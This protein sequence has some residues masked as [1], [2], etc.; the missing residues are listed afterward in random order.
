MIRH[1]TWNESGWDTNGTETKIE[2]QISNCQ[3]LNSIRQP[4]KNCTRSRTLIGRH[5]FH[6]RNSNGFE[7]HVK[8]EATFGLISPLFL[9]LSLSPSLYRSLSLSPLLPLYLLSVC[10]LSVASS[11]S[12]SERFVFLQFHSLSA[13]IMSNFRILPVNNASDSMFDRPK[14]C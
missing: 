4:G 7:F 8:F 6:E 11:L 14:Q 12:A 13:M 2:I 10:S 3:F 5:A 1:A 9:G